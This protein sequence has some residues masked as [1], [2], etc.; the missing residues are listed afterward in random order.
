VK[1]EDGRDLEPERSGVQLVIED[2]GL[3]EADRVVADLAAPGFV[4]PAGGR[5]SGC[6]ASDGWAS[7]AGGKVQTYLNPSG[8]VDTPV[9]TPGSAAGLRRLKVRDRVAAR[10]VI[11]FHARILAP[12][13][14]IVGPLRGALTLGG[15]LDAGAVGARLAVAC[16]PRR[17]GVSGGIR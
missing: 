14:D 13:W 4:V 3:P 10:G 12:R 9:C 5:G 8:S 6:G 16:A 15:S 11:E 2:L 7:S 1:A 17:V